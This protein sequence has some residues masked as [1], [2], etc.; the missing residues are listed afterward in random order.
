MGHRRTPSANDGIGDWPR[1]TYNAASVIGIADGDA[2]SARTLRD[3]T[4]HDGIWC[5]NRSSK[6]PAC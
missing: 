6:H 4:G 3:L 2:G 1:E 5:F